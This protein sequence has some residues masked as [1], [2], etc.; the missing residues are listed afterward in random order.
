MWAEVPIH[1]V[2]PLL[3]SNFARLHVLYWIKANS[4]EKLELGK[5]FS[6]QQKKNEQKQLSKCGTWEKKALYNI[7]CLFWL[8]ARFGFASNCQLVHISNVRNA[9][10][11]DGR[12]RRKCQTEMLCCTFKWIGGTDKL[13]PNPVRST[14]Y[15]FFEWI[16]E[17]K[18]PFWTDKWHVVW[19][20]VVLFPHF[21]VLTC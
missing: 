15:K 6:L 4:E 16:D 14:S 11:I 1:L 19:I 21:W 9:E 17:W 2:R 5:Q 13:N 7:L 18:Y 10:G 8:V 20:P 12:A 3:R